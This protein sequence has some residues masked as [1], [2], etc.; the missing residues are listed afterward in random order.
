MAGERRRL[1][2]IPRRPR[3]EV[4]L[5]TRDLRVLREPEGIAPRVIVTIATHSR[6]NSL[7]R[8]LRSVC[9]QDVDPATLGVVVLVDEPTSSAWSPELPRELEGKVWLLA[10]NCGSPARV[11]NAM[12]EYVERCIPSCR[13][14]ARLDWD[15]RFALPSSLREAVEVGDQAGAEFVLGGNRV[16]DQD[17]RCLR[18]N[19]AAAWLLDRELVTQRLR[20]MAAGTAEN[21]LPSCNL[22]V[23]T[24][25]RI[26]YP[27][28]PSAEDHWLV[29]DL[30]CHQSHRVA[31][32]KGL[33]LV[34]YTLGGRHTTSAKLSQRHRA[35][36]VALAAAAETWLRVAG[37][38]GRLLGLGQEGIV[39]ECGGVVQ[40]H[41][42]EGIL[43]E[44][45][46][47][48]LS[49]TLACQE[50]VP[51]AEWRPGAVAGTWIAEYPW[52]D[53][54][55]FE[56]PD[57]CAVAEFLKGSL[58]T[59]VV[60]GN[61]KRTN[62]RV[63]RD[64]RLLYIDLG[65]WIVPTD[66]S[67][68]LDSAARLYSIGVLGNSDEEV[69][70]RA[71]DHSRPEIWDR[72]E[73]FS[74][75]Y[76]E[77]VGAELSQTWAG[78]R[79]VPRV[80]ARRREDVSLLIK[81]CA[82]D[83]GCLGAQVR[84]IV[85]QLTQP[86]DFAE[87]VLCID[88][89]EGPFL[90]QHREGDLKAT[91][92]VGQDLVD[93]GVVDRLLVAPT[94]ES[95]VREVNRR[96]FDVAIGKT[97]TAKGLPVT[98]HVWAFDQLRTKFVLQCD[99]DVLIG[100]R[101]AAHDYL[102]EMVTACHAGDVVGVAFNIPHDPA[103]PVREYGAVAGEF[104]PEVRCGL[105]DLERLRALRPLECGSA[106]EF[107]TEG[108]YH[109][110]WKRQRRDGLR[111]VRGG[112]PRTFY[113]HP[114]NSV[115]ADEEGLARVRSVVTLGRVPRDA[116][117]RWDL[118]NDLSG[119]EYQKRDETLVVVARGR[120]TPRNKLDRFAGSLEAQL[121]QSFG[122]VVIDD[123]STDG[124]C[125]Y[126]MSRLRPFG[127]RLTFV[128]RAHQKGRMENLVYAVRELCVRDAT[129]VV[130]LDLDDALAH[131][132][133]IGLLARRFGLGHDL[134]LAA[135]FRP[136]A[137]TR[138]YSPDFRDPRAAYGGDVWMHLRSFTRG[139][140]LQLPDE[141][142]KERGEWLRMCEDYATMIPMAEIARSPVYVPEFTY[143]HER[144]T[145][146]DPQELRERGR[147]IEYLLAMGRFE[148]PQSC[149]AGRG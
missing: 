92:R 24:T 70:R 38:P 139:L 10:A 21:E 145:S 6:A 9:D 49:S 58:R 143:W 12:L 4:E 127:E 55:A 138:L 132:D 144:T 129:G 37:T 103:L 26:R 73:G 51:T 109:C 80:E 76:G 2:V 124:S 34:D 86:S 104:K 85:E 25:A 91:L 101:D 56:K 60:C 147:I 27:D 17:G 95:V 52:E 3:A 146:K 14:I 97:H 61:I 126:A 84:H 63:G 137:P 114:L 66:V 46:V 75:F 15:D 82:M 115:K 28:T 18:E 67:V 113:V 5:T 30:L 100:R 98:P 134:V 65:N 32:Y 88:P 40:K 23:R 36:R 141:R 1:G 116:W 64:G 33:P 136:D 142:L 96:W 74:S 117:G 19:S 135:S 94:D 71:A 125:E 47:S 50:I 68:L 131:E 7:D 112:D 108:W 90:R 16:L 20:E 120:N 119:W 99:V 87:R 106:G 133:A 57:V 45:K 41:F 44:E 77:V 78:G 62:F 11:R 39:R 43:S 121:D 8:C 89:F 110:L 128:A 22:L 69:L 105:L 148:R 140:F 59:N 48:W 149:D 83:G 107:M 81:A 53:T 35:S 42:Y 79:G 72:L 122:L 13:W 93:A 31:L 111:T 29:A 123:A 118:Q 130:V 102:G 54:S